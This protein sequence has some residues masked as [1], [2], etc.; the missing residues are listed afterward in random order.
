MRV[1]LRRFNG[2]REP[3]QY[4]TEEADKEHEDK[5]IGRAHV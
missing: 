2:L 4:F 3:M 1:C 5:Q